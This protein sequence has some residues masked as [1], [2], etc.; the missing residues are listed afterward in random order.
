MKRLLA[1]SIA[2][3]ALLLVPAFPRAAG[4][5][6]PAAGTAA[7]DTFLRGQV[8]RGVVPGVVAV[9]VNR[10][11]VLY[12]GAFGK[13][14]I[15]K[16]VAL[17]P[18]SIFRI[19][20]MTKAVTS[21]ATMMM[22]EQGKLK[23]DDDVS[24]YL[25]AFASMQVLTRY[26]EKAGTYETKP[27]TKAITIRQLLTHTSG[28]G[29]S[30]SDP[31]LALVQRKTNKAG[32][33]EL[34]LVHAPGEKW[35]YGASTKVL[36]DVVEKLSGERIDAFTDRHIAK[37]LGMKDTFYEVPASE[38]PRVVTTHQKDATGTLTETQNPATL[39]VSLRGDGG[40]F[41]TAPDYGRFLQMLLNGGRLGNVRILRASTVADMLKPQTNGVRVR[42]Q[43]VA[44]EGLSKPYPLGAG[45]DIWGLG[46]QLAD[47]KKADPA[48]RRP[49]SG[50]WAG[51]FN[52][53]FWVD[54]KE[55]LGVV[56]MMQMLPFYDAGALATLEGVERRV[57]SNLR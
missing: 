28:I 4:R 33:T 23:L 13:Q 11:D 8:D 2:V 22:V 36:G 25:P 49:G 50:N 16:N 35:T 14:N 55:E 5:T 20:S 32:E 51:I 37:P 54:P 19:A 30:W 43:P 45:E 7:L 21:V 24:T 6:L 42:L 46:F 44:S 15:A 17:T 29:Y 1:A 56:V 27:N 39:P 9:V 40:L 41:S 38:Y 34:P 12:S 3:A 18:R 48:L 10:T 26:D 52:T 57:Y 31:G 47:P 53:F